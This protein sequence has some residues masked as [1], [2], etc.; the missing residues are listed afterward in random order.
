[1]HPV[2]VIEAHVVEVHA[3]AGV[4]YNSVLNCSIAALLVL[5]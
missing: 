1:V 3:V 2:M 5:S 4:T